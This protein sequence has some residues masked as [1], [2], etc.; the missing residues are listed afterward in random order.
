[1]EKTRAVAFVRDNFFGTY[2]VLMRRVLEAEEFENKS[3]A[4][5]G[6]VM[7]IYARCG[8]SL[9]ELIPRVLENEYIWAA[10]VHP[11]LKIF[12]KMNE[13]E[14]YMAHLLKS[15]LLHIGN[16]IAAGILYL[17]QV[18]RAEAVAETPDTQLIGE[19]HADLAVADKLGEVVERCFKLIV[20]RLQN[21]YQTMKKPGILQIVF[22]SD[23]YE[24]STGMHVKTEN[25]AHRPLQSA[26]DVPEARAE[27]IQ[28][29]PEDYVAANFINSYRIRPRVRTDLDINF[30]D[31]DAYMIALLYVLTKGVNRAET[32]NELYIGN[33]LIEAQKVG[34]E[35]FY[36][37]RSWKTGRFLL[38]ERTA[39]TLKFYRD[40]YTF[41]RAFL[42]ILDV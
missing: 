25:F 15:E 34:A 42:N 26:Y 24:K 6:I 28:E 41:A 12:L 1:M 16:Q 18:A 17:E 13:M 21:I 22:A 39:G 32:P 23:A 10:L 19:D 14:L 9:D 31:Q 2:E 5:I 30:V 33:Y 37:I 11:E 20:S 3:A 38:W 40:I 29:L 8:D 27:A 4:A 7:L 36:A 35:G